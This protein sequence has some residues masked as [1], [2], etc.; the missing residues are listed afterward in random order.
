MSA[1][2]L[3]RGNS[4]SVTISIA[5]ITPTPKHDPPG[6]PVSLGAPRTFALRRAGG[7]RSTTFQLGFGDLFVMGGSCQLAY[8]HAIP[9][10]RADGARMA[11][12][13]RPVIPVDDEVPIP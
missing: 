13:F 9:K 10:E 11:V 5:I 7:G 8:E 2:T 4:T 1:Q 3:S 6:I 12:M